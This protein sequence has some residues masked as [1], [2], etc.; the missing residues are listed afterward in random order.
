ME[1]P[2]SMRETAIVFL[3]YKLWIVK[4]LRRP[5]ETHYR[6]RQIA[7]ERWNIVGGLVDIEK[8]ANDLP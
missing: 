6:Q 8:A 5:V 2:T 3:Y 7:Q 4:G 1:S